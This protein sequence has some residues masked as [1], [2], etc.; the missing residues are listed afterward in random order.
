[1][2]ETAPP[3]AHAW[4][5]VGE[6]LRI[7]GDRL[8]VHRLR[9]FLGAKYIHPKCLIGKRSRVDRP[10]QVRMD[11][12]CVL[13]Q[14]VWLSLGSSSAIFELGEFG[15]IGRGTEIEVSER[16]TIGRGALIAP[17]VYITDHNHQTRLGAGA[18]YEMPC[19]AAPVTIGADV[20][21]GTRCVILPGVTIGDGA[22]IAAG[23]VVTRD[24]PPNAIAAG[25]PARVIRMRNAA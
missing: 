1:M 8:R 11:Q 23:A 7:C 4:H 15:F 6:F 21:I 22:V 16:V 3:L 10:W 2:S 20:W 5:R 24:V 13:Q 14:D 19:V 9:L 17:D 25:I 18:M 12:R